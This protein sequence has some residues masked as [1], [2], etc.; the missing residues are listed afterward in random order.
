ME[1][2]EVIRKRHSVR[3]FDNTPV[4]KDKVDEIIKS[5]LMA[6]SA[7]NIKDYRIVVVSDEKTKKALSDAAFGQK[8]LIE[9]PIVLVIYSDLDEI[10]MKYNQRGIDIFSIEDTAAMSENILLSATNLGLGSCWVGG[11]EEEKVKEALDLSGHKKPY[12]IIPIGYEKGK[13]EMKKDPD[14][15]KFVIYK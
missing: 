8:H 13:R 12:V 2:N 4:N 9:A 1:F 10:F 11:F 3:S 15:N 6:P 5:G 7:G 14:L